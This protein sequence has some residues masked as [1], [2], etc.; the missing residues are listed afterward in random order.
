[1]ATK[2]E[3]SDVVDSEALFTVT[4]LYAQDTTGTV[5]VINCVMRLLDELDRRG[6]LLEP[7]ALPPIETLTLTQLDDRGKVVKEI[8]ESERKYVQ[9][10][11]VLQ[12]YQRKLSQEDIIS[13]DTIHAI[14]LNLNA[15]VDFQRRFLIGVEAHASQPS[16]QQRFGHL[17]LS[18]VRQPSSLFTEGQLAEQVM[19][20]RRALAF[21]NP[22][23]PTLAPPRTFVYKS[24]STSGLV[25]HHPTPL[26]VLGILIW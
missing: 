3:L 25:Y 12:D 23:A 1:M 4:Q 9:D 26:C 6:L 14:F 19:N 22:T 11:E 20:R 2:A 8:L 21:T 17:F 10:L 5:Q 18:M 7:T 16:D 24:L 13:Q 15:L